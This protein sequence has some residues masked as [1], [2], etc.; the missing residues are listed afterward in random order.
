MY[1]SYNISLGI[2]LAVGLMLFYLPSDPSVWVYLTAVAGIIN[3]STTILFR[4]VRILML[5]FF[6]GTK[7]N[8]F[9]SKR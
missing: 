6:S 7:Y 2:V 8:P 3:L 4:Y 9:Y 5:Y 1:I